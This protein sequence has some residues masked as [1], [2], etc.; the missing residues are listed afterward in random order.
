MGQFAAIA[1]VRPARLILMLDDGVS[2][3]AIMRAVKC[4]TR[5]ISTSKARFAQQRLA[6]LSGRHPGRAPRHG[7]ARLQARVL[8]YTLKRSPR[9]GSTHWSSRRLAAEGGVTFMDIQ[10]I[11]RRHALKPHRL[12]GMASN[13]RHVQAKA[14]EVIGL[15]L[16]P[17]A[18][19]AVFSVDE[20]T[21]IQAVHRKDRML[22]LSPARAQSH[23]VV[24]KRNATLSLFGAF[25][26]ST[27]DV[28]GK[29]A[30]RHT[31]AQFVAFLSEVLASQPEGRDIHV[32]CD[33]VSR[34][35]TA[36]VA[37]FLAQ[38]P[39]VTMHF[40]PTDSS[41]LNHGE[42]CFA[43]IQRDVIT[44]GIFTRTTDLHKMLMR[45]IRQHHQNT[46]PTIRTYPDPPRRIRC[47]ASVLVDP[48]HRIGARR[49]EMHMMRHI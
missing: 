20:K 1:Q 21:A 42:N 24:S 19:A 28:M 10:R 12:E 3:D 40:T 2:R 25:H 23:G 26:T 47:N 29:T 27:G 31:S 48:P 38:Y 43:N 49:V 41:W 11:I 14:A 22:A 32:I 15:S 17:P 45:Y 39:N 7:L 46:K 5:F 13:D 8:N 9:D 16:N 44:R 34:H 36:H 37:A 33:N 35:N 4:D 6:G 18:N 30:P